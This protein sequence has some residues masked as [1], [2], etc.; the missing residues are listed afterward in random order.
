MATD[1]VS[2]AVEQSLVDLLRNA[3]AGDKDATN[4]FF[5]AIRPTVEQEVADRKGGQILNGLSAADIV[6]E[7]LL[8]ISQHV[9]EAR[10]TSDVEILAWVKQSARNKF[11][12]AARKQGRRQHNA[13]QR[14]FPENS[15]GAVSV[16]A[17]T[18]SPSHKAMRNEDTAALNSALSQLSSEEQQVFHLRYFKQLPF[19]EIAAQTGRTDVAVRQ[20]HLRAI[21]RLR[22][23]MG[24]AL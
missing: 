15:S 24:T 20:M 3:R 5:Q 2:H 22:E 18:S 4:R 1:P 19:G 14:A 11:L 7:C 6:Q 23:L 16:P 21:R 12:D 8:A 13:P 17:E 10:A 9:N